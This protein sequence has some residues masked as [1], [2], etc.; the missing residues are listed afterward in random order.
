MTA[1][2]PFTINSVYQNSVR[3]YVSGSNVTTT[4]QSAASVTGLAFSIAANEKWVA[5]VHM[6]VGSSSVAGMSVAVSFP[7]GAT[8]TADW[9]GVT[10]TNPA[11]AWE[12][13]TA[14]G[15]LTTTSFDT[16]SATTAAVGAFVNGEITVA[17]GATPGTVQV[18]FAKT[19]SGTATVY[20]G[21]FMTAHRLA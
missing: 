14:S 16:L 11:T 5:R 8:V 10:L 15:T 9:F 13:T 21:S 4:G 12:Q 1:Y 6:K 7:A 20:V 19:T 3:V 18:Q 17:N 2:Q